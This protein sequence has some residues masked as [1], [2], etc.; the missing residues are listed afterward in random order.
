ML[1][2]FSVVKEQEVVRRHLDEDTET[3]FWLKRVRC[4]NIQFEK[5]TNTVTFTAG[6]HR[7]WCHDLQLALVPQL[8]YVYPAGGTAHTLL[9]SWAVILF[10]SVTIGLSA[11]VKW[12]THLRS[13]KTRHS[14]GSWFA[15]I[16][17]APCSNIN[18]W[19]RVYILVINMNE[20]QYLKL[21]THTHTAP[22]NFSGSL[23]MSQVQQLHHAGVKHITDAKDHYSW[24]LC[25][26][27]QKRLKD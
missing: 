3:T 18:A 22:V 21:R 13:W 24:E 2:A 17:P 10:K 5:P 8:V 9:T 20:W 11:P 7:K 19:L 25:L 27:G 16:P 1:L 12:R 23:F 26:L 15:A 4:N 6:C 14:F